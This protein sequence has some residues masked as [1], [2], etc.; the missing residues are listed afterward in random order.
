MKK[1]YK[2]LNDKYDNKFSNYLVVMTYAVESITESKR[3]SINFEELCKLS[4]DIVILT[5]QNRGSTFLTLVVPE[6]SSDLQKIESAITRIYDDECLNQEKYMSTLEETE[7]S[8]K[9]KELLSKN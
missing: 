7:E 9:I 1:V 3:T 5:E 2:S 8:L 6:S 4:A